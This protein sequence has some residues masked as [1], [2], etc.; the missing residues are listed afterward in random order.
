MA[1]LIL[2]TTRVGISELYIKVLAKHS[3]D[4]AGSILL[5]FFVEDEI[6]I[7]DI[8]TANN[9]ANA[10]YVIFDAKQKASEMMYNDIIND[11][12]AIVAD[13]KMCVQAA[14]A[15]YRKNPSKLGA[16]G[17]TVNG[18]RVVYSK[19]RKTLCDDMMNFI[20]HNASLAVALRPITAAFQTTNKM[21]LAAN[22]AALPG[23]KTAIDVYD[24]ELIDK[25]TS[26]GTYSV[27]EKT[28]IDFL[29]ATGHFLMEQFPLNPKKAGDWS[30]V[31]DD[32]PQDAKEKIKNFKKGQIANLYN[33]VADSILQNTG[34][35]IQEITK[36]KAGTG[37]PI[38]LNPG[39][40]WQV[41]PG[42][43]T[44]KA[45]SRGILLTGQITYLKNNS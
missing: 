29:R 9:A 43:T 31:V 33:I 5:P 2:P 12:D 1:R 26:H 37:T 45:K 14:K 8:T 15:F 18:N 28:V 23:I 10:A 41:L 6:V 40:H 20:N 7:G 16:F 3:F 13:H 22:L 39:D 44:S 42:Y 4:G 30:F 36:G 38:V 27:E 32:S 25:E 35:S 11:F 19:H 24:Q 34:D 17:V 21:D